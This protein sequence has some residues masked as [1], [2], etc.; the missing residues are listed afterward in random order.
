MGPAKGGSAVKTDRTMRPARQRLN[1]D[2]APAGMLF[3]S[4]LCMPKVIEF[5]VEE[6]IDE[7]CDACA[8]VTRGDDLCQFLDCGKVV[9]DR[10]PDSTDLQKG[11][12]IFG[13]AD[14]DCLVPTDP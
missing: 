11:P 7:F 8:V 5:P 14:A 10:R 13:I 3:R 12:I 1:L 4:A 9:G 2:G 6:T